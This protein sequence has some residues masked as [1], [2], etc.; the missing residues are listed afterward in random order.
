[1]GVTFGRDR[2]GGKNIIESPF[3]FYIGKLFVGDFYAALNLPPVP[4]THTQKSYVL[5]W[6]IWLRIK[7]AYVSLG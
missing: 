2:F 7:L 6:L 4:Y 3:S 1:M 5:F